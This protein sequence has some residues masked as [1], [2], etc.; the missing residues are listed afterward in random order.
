MR[1]RLVIT[2][3]LGTL[4]AVLAAG[5]VGAQS[6][7]VSVDL[8]GGGN[9]DPGQALPA[10]SNLS[11]DDGDG[12]VDLG[13]PGCANPLDGDETNSA[14]TTTSPTTT[15]PSSTTTTSTTEVQ[16]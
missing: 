7:G 10:C 3:V 16:P 4:L 1:N 14:P 5:A 6:T 2:M 11:D 9:I 12:A 13:D 8:P 15:V